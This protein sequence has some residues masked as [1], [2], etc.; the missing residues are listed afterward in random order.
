M[1]MVGQG[2]DVLPTC[3]ADRYQGNIGLDSK[4]AHA[5]HRERQAHVDHVGEGKEWDDT[6]GHGHFQ[7]ISFREQLRQLVP[8]VVE[9]KRDH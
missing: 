4:G 9:R 3:G 5:A 7:S 8:E 2:L 6:K 1:H